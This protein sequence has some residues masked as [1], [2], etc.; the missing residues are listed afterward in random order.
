MPFRSFET[1]CPRCGEPLGDG[2]LITGQRIETCPACGGSLI[3]APVIEK[4]VRWLARWP[5][6][7]LPA[8]DARRPPIAC[9]TCRLPMKPVVQLGIATDVCD[10]HGVWLDAGELQA[11]LAAAE[12]HNRETRCAEC[13]RPTELAMAGGDLI[14]RCRPCARV[15][16]RLQ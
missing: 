15:V 6:L 10:R 4:L 8:R 16:V 1:G 3:A 5:A 12:E 2:E 9:P 14:Q 7:P 13:G 11:L